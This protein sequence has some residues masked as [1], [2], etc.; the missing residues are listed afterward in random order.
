MRVIMEIR[1]WADRIAHMDE[2][3]R[4][5]LRPMLD[6]VKADTQF[7]DRLTGIRD[8]LK[9]KWGTLRE[10]AALTVFFR[11]NLLD[12]LN[13]LQTPKNTP[14]SN[15]A[16]ALERRCNILYAGKFIDRPL[17]MALYEDVM[18]FIRERAEEITDYFFVQKMEQA[19]GELGYELLSDDI[20]ATADTDTSLAPGQVR[21]AETPYEGYRVMLKAD[22][23][24][25]STRL[26]RVKENAEKENEALSQ[27]QRQKDLEIGKKWC[28]DLDNFL[29][30]MRRQNLTLDVTLRKEPEEVELMTV[31]DPNARAGKKK[32][33][34]SAEGGKLKERTV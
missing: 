17:F 22:K 28:H 5:K 34:K 2:N 20:G 11:E 29:E 15:E 26:V 21:Y 27:D 4:E 8:Q 3:E 24:T 16:A 14:A 9:T 18:R 6:K 12:L 31:V 1:D 30:K 32:R 19:L 33:K 13:L 10:R 7:P 25:V 23:G